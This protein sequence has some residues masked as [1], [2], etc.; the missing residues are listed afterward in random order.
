MLGE[1]PH[2]LLLI[3]EER[4]FAQQSLVPREGALVLAHREACEE[5]NGLHAD[6]NP[7]P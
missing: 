7:Q 3:R 2:R 4:G 5:V 1:F 6:A